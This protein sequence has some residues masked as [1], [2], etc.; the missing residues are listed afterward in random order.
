MDSIVNPKSCTHP[1]FTI[2]SEKVAE[3]DDQGSAMVAR[4]EKCKTAISILPRLDVLEKSFAAEISRQLA[5]L[6]K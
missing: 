3:T 5:A 1:T 4:C 6:R 2:Y